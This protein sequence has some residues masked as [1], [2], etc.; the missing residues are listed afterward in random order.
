MK[1]QDVTSSIIKATL[2]R[3]G[4]YVAIG[5]PI[6]AEAVV[7]SIKKPGMRIQG[8]VAI[9]SRKLRELE[10]AKEIAPC[11]YFDELE[12]IVASVEYA[13]TDP[14]WEQ[15]RPDNLWL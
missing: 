7:I 11:D 14:D 5:R 8:S 3:R 6:D 15:G 1:Q 4:W 2:E 13:A 10:R 9:H 12:K